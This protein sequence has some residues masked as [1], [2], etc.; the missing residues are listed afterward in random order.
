MKKKSFVPVAKIKNN[1]RSIYR[2]DKQRNIAKQRCKVDIATYECEEC[3]KYMYEGKPEKRFLE[4]TERHPDKV[5]VRGKPE[6]DHVNPVV[7]VKKGFGTWDDY[8]NSLWVGADELKC[9]CRECHAEKSAEEMAE[10]KKHGS[11]KRG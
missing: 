6:I 2:H 10:R 1:L 11:L 5:V 9:I 8:I 7:N 4:I 3:A